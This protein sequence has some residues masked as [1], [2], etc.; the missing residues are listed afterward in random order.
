MR[1]SSSLHFYQISVPLNLGSGYGSNNHARIAVHPFIFFVLSGHMPGRLV[2]IIDAH[3]PFQETFETS[4]KRGP[5]CLIWMWV[6][7]LK[8]GVRVLARRGEIERPTPVWF[9]FSHTCFLLVGFFTISWAIT[10]AFPDFCVQVGSKRGYLCTWPGRWWGLIHHSNW[11]LIVMIHERLLLL[12]NVQSNQDVD[13]D[14]HEE[15]KSAYAWNIGPWNGVST[16]ATRKT[17]CPTKNPIIRSWM[18][19]SYSLFWS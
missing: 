11:V 9:T 5:I 16:L 7:M 3:M 10:S 2:E 18:H 6:W 13:W 1:A 19:W 8:E 12:R 17:V 4:R 14:I 15:G